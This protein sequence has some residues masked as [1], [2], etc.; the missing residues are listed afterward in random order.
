[1]RRFEFTGDSLWIFILTALLASCSGPQTPRGAP[2]AMPQSR[3]HTDRGASWIPT[4]AAKDSLLF[5]SDEGTSD[6][7]VYSLSKDRLVGTLTGFSEPR[8][9]CLN[10]A[11]DI[12]IT[13]AGESNLL[14]YAPGGSEPIGSL[15]D[16]GEYPVDCS[17]NT[18]TGDLSA[19]NI[20]SV[21]EG[22][23]SLSVY[24]TGI[25]VPA[26]APAFAHTY[27][28]AY[29][30]AG[31]LFIDGASNLGRFQFGELVRGQKTVT[32]LALK[33]ATITDPTNVQYA[34]G[35]LAIGAERGY[36]G[37]STIYQL[38][39]SGTTATV[40]GRTRL[41]DANVIA[42]FIVGH[43]VFCLDST[44]YRGVHVAIYKYPD[45]GKPIRI[46]KIPGLSMPVGLAVGT[47]AN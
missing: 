34:D 40:V 11:G 31:N 43:R 28:D 44:T 3:A 39:V 17:V 4:D 45:G 35:H 21:K 22:P 5:V 14:E 8:G 24:R 46:I 29:D 41:Q 19:S 25:G 26:I 42:F 7:Y 1:V 33:G 2:E 47:P 6:V 30:P 36:L 16:P 37:N 20:I 10:K 9:V 32:Q 38:A 12:W 18:V 15:D 27:N 13:N 23:G